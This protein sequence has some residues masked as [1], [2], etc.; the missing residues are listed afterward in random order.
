MKWGLLG[1]AAAGVG[2]V[3]DYMSNQEESK[4]KDE[5]IESLR[6]RVV[7]LENKINGVVDEPFDIPI[8]EKMRMWLNKE[9]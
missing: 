6:K 2:L 3:C 5:E 8:S 1:M 9:V 7:N 4:K